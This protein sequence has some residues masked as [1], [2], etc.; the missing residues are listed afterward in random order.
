MNYLIVGSGGVGGCIG[1][2]LTKAGKDVTL[3]ARNAHLKAMKQKGVILEDTKG[4][5]EVIPVKAMELKDYKEKADVI[6]L[7]VKGYSIASLVDEL[8]RVSDEKTVI[9]PILNVYG[10][11][12]KLQKELQAQVCDGCIYI[13]SEKKEAGTI[14]MKGSIFRIVYGLSSHE[15][16]P[17]LLAIKKDLEDSGIEAVLSDNIQRDA[18]EKYAYITSAVTCGLYY[19][20]T[21]GD[22]QKE[23]KE[24]ELFK[25]LNHEIELLACAMGIPFEKDMVKEN[26]AILD[27]LSP[28]SSTSMQRDIAQGNPSEI[29]GLIYEVGR[30]AK[31]YRVELPH[32]QEIIA[33]LQR[34]C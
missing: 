4:N 20:A 26:V 21:A 11:G 6:F 8:K 18:F 31:Q 12:D 9:I 7:C 19:H 14:L 24:R 16:P 10:T 25:A 2:Y 3:I 13:A 34:F 33:K 28:L 30:L 1:A 29:D 32:F 5:Q 27:T 23:G 15:I 17:R 22:M